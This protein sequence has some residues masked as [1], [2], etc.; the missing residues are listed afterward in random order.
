MKKMLLKLET[1]SKSVI[2]IIT[3]GTTILGVLIGI[4]HGN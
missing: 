4:Y 1:V 2:A 3:A